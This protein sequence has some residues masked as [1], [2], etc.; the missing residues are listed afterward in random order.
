MQPIEYTYNDGYA[1]EEYDEKPKKKRSFKWL[2]I[3]LPILI[4][5]GA[6]IGGIFLVVQCTHAKAHPRA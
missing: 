1:Y 4:A 2:F 3:V 5:I 6:T